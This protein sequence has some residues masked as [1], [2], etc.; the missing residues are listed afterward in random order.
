MGNRRFHAQAIAARFAAD[1]FLSFTA[2]FTQSRLTQPCQNIAYWRRS[3]IWMSGMPHLR[4]DI[5]ESETDA[6]TERPRRR[7]SDKVLLAFDQA[8]DQRNLVVAERLVRVLE[9]THRRGHEMETLVT[10]YERLWKL[11]HTL[12]LDC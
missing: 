12:M 7:L 11:Q 1:A 8:C 10:V 6:V 4:A 5:G 3:P 9:M 2:Q